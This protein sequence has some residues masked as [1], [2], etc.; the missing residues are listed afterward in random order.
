[1]KDNLY[2]DVQ[3]QLNVSENKAKELIM[4]KEG[5]RHMHEVFFFY[6]LHERHRCGIGVC[7][8]RVGCVK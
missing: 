8:A 3:K 2:Y 1:M 6:P 7:L 5:T 4:N